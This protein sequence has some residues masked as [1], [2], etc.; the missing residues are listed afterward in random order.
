MWRNTDHGWGRISIALHWLSAIA[1]IVLFASGW[2]MTGLDYYDPWWRITPWWH[3]SFGMLLIFVT[4]ARIVWRLLL[5]V[6][7]GHGSA[8]SRN[9]AHYGH[10]LLYLLLLTVLIS[11]Y[12][13]STDDGD[14]VIFFGWFEIPAVI[15]HL[16]NQA[17]IAGDIHWYAAWALIILA[18]GHGLIALKHHFLDKQDTLVRMLGSRSSRNQNKR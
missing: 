3:R 9:A 1:V 4:L 2:W 16:P 8:L 6:P 11:G 10:L 18:V 13:M 15:S 7:K 5:P 17:K 12:L 14:G